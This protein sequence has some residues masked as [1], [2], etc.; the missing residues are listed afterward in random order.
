MADSNPVARGSALWPWPQAGSWGY[1]LFDLA[2]TNEWEVRTFSNRVGGAPGLHDYPR[3]AQ[4]VRG[5][6]T[7]AVVAP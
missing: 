2:A 3:R 4:V 7:S 6:P 1:D 5:W